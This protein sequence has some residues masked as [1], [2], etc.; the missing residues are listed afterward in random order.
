MK[1]KSEQIYEPP[2]E[3]EIWNRG[4]SQGFDEGRVYGFVTGFIISLVAIVITWLS[5]NYLIAAVIFCVLLSLLLGIILILE[6]GYA[7]VNEEW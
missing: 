1:P 7:I 4:R 3:H 2:L 6:L 5:F